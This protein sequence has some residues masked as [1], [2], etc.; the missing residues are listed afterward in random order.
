[1]MYMQGVCIANILESIEAEIAY[2]CNICGELFN[3]PDDAQ[4]HN[5]TAHTES[6]LKDDSDRG[7]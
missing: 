2:K 6:E 5:Q 3:S 7:L 4:D 1:M